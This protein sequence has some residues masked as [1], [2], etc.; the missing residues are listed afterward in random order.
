MYCIANDPP[1][2]CWHKDIIRKRPTAQTS[3]GIALEIAGVYVIV[4]SCMPV[5][6]HIIQHLHEY[7]S[8]INNKN[9]AYPFRRLKQVI[10]PS[11]AVHVANSDANKMLRLFE[12]LSR[13]DGT[14]EECLKTGKFL[15][16]C[17]TFV[18]GRDCK[19]GHTKEQ[20]APSIDQWAATYKHLKRDANGDVIVCSECGHV[21]TAGKHDPDAMSPIDRA[22]VLYVCSHSIWVMLARRVEV[23]ARR[24]D[25]GVAVRIPLEVVVRG[26]PLAH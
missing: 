7:I 5:D 4:L 14:T 22:H 24:S 9:I 8:E 21:D 10:S 2:S 16:A 17:T 12:S 26:S 25:D 6:F 15:L 20:Q 1:G 19:C 23:P 13:L 3:P 11:T 18:T